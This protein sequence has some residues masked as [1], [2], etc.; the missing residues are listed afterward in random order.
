MSEYSSQINERAYQGK[1]LSEAQEHSNKA[2]SRVRS[3]VEHV[4]GHMH[5]S[6]A[7]IFMDTIGIAHAKVG[8]TL[9][10]L[11]YNLSRIEALIRN[12]TFALQGFQCPNQGT[13]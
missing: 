12:K 11:T 4:F 10:N 6:M 8:V 13:P 7:G 9:M 5:S 3:R 2:K 1:P